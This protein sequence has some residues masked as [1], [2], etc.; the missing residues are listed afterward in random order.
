MFLAVVIEALGG[1]DKSLELLFVVMVSDYLTGIMC[2]ISG[3]SKKCSGLN[4]YIGFKGLCKKA[5]MLIV[6]WVASDI[7]SVAR[8]SEIK[9]LT[10]FSAIREIFIFAFISNELISI[11]EN[12]GLM[13]VP[14]PKK[15]MNV[16]DVLKER[17]E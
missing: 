3:K 13:G 17:I 1:W 7:S 8:L 2:A 12:C 11:T 15:I 6:V 14:I 5:T 9:E 4:S 16:I 10:G